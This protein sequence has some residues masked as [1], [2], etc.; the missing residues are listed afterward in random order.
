VTRYQ[1]EFLDPISGQWTPH[2]PPARS[3]TAATIVGLRLVPARDIRVLAVTDPEMMTIT[4]KFDTQ[5][6]NANG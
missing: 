1:L 2:G 6:E 4:C 3:M 5:E